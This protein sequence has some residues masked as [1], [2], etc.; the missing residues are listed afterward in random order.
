MFG[1]WARGLKTWLHRFDDSPGPPHVPSGSMPDTGFRFAPELFECRSEVQA[2]LAEADILWLS[3]YSSVDPLHDL[4]G[5]E[6]CG[7]KEEETAER[8][9]RLLQR[10][11]PQWGFSRCCYK[12]W[13]TRDVGWKVD[14][15]R[16]SRSRGS[17][18][19]AP[20]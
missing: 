4:Y 11:F 6:V 17:G 19:G 5:V 10:R 12:D 3:H 20:W 16:D 1:K 15:H 14:I 9:L 7:I 18:G 8:I 13:G 2:L